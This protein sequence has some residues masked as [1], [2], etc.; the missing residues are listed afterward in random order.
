MRAES[1]AEVIYESVCMGVCV[2][3][4]VRVLGASAQQE[5]LH[6]AP[7]TSSVSKPPLLMEPPSPTGPEKPGSVV[8]C[9]GAQE[10]SFLGWCLLSVGAQVFG[11]PGQCRS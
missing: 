10:G 1:G 2:C 3:A 4:C 9:L 7:H 5:Q 6:S 11:S 8:D